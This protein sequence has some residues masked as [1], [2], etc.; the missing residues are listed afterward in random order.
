MNSKMNNSRRYLSREAAIM[1]FFWGLYLLERAF[2]KRIPSLSIDELAFTLNY[3]LASCFVNYVL[4]P[5]LFYKGKYLY[6]VTAVL[7]TV[8]VA[9]L[10]EE[11]ALETLFYPTSVRARI[12]NPVYA[13]IYIGIIL[14][15]FAGL[16]FGFDAWKNQRLINKLERE[17]STSQMEHLKAQISPHF[18]FNNMNNLYSKALE[19][20]DETPQL[21]LQLA[22]IMR[23]MLYE[24][25][26]DFVS[27]AKEL[28]HVLDYV[29]MQK[30]QLEDRGEIDF[31]ITGDSYQGL[32]IA[33]FLLIGFIENCFKH[34]FS[35][36]S[37]KILI[38]IHIAI[39]GS[40]LYLTCVNPS[41]GDR[42]RVNESLP[43]GIGLKNVKSRLSLIYPDRHTLEIENINRLF[44][45]KL[46]LD[47]SS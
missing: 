41:D 34:S 1:V 8:I 2:A 39:K 42:E 38:Q 4:I 33:P 28:E 21:I 44:I 29:A 43:K 14:L 22:N 31:V 9:M 24:S 27:L 16:K 6:F 23:Y 18:F 17:K 5:R 46:S 32:Q 36:L 19:R 30:V 15:I 25:Q 13:A 20:S 40:M 37:E 45:V 7:L 12:F 3:I 10:L 35:D 11:L 47:L 26:G